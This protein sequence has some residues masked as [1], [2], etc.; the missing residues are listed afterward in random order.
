MVPEPAARL[1]MLIRVFGI[2]DDF[3]EKSHVEKNPVTYTCT[4]ISR[5]YC[6]VYTKL[7][8]S[9]QRTTLILGDKHSLMHGK[10]IDILPITLFV[11]HQEILIRDTKLDITM[12]DP[13]S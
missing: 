6:T 2:R 11:V 13:K 9:V 7:R 1:H 5:Y 4:E 8:N 3:A 10:T 12:G